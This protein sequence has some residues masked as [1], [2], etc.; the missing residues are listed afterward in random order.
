MVAI[1]KHSKEYDVE[2]N[3]L[4]KHINE[5]ISKFARPVFL[6]IIHDD[7]NW[8]VVTGTLKLRKTELQR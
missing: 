2:I 4:A 1:R 7:H 6:R 5:H 8:E 3:E